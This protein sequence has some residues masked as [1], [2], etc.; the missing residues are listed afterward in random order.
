MRL[1]ADYRTIAL[2]NGAVENFLDRLDGEGLE[3]HR[4]ADVS[5]LLPRS[6]QSIH[7][8]GAH[9]DGYVGQPRVAAELDG[10]CDPVLTLF[11]HLEVKDHGVRLVGANLLGLDTGR[12]EANGLVVEV[13]QH[14]AIKVEDA[15]VVVDH[16][17]SPPTGWISLPD[18][19]GP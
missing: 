15:W 17:N 13:A 1:I 11:A 19:H 12:R 4:Y 8:R 2:R 3:Q 10:R 16:D 9:D 14:V 18:S 6:I 7:V 5:E